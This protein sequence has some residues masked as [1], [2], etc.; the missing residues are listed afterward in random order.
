MNQNPNIKFVPNSADI[1]TAH[2]QAAETGVI[3]GIGSRS[4]PWAISLK[5]FAHE[6]SWHISIEGPNGYKWDFKFDGNQQ[7]IE[8]ISQTIDQ[9]LR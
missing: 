3:K 1:P 6:S 8:N 7:S 5:E 4:G 2:R 9:A